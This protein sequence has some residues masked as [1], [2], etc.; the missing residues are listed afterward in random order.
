MRKQKV[1]AYRGSELRV[2]VE[3]AGIDFA[4]DC[5]NHRV[6]SHETN[7]TRISYVYITAGDTFIDL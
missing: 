2:G 7:E 6:V 1:L 4:S 3:N 5:K